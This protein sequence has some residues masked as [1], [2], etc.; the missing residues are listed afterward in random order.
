[1]PTGVLKVTEGMDN[2]YSCK[3]NQSKKCFFILPSYERKA[4]YKACLAFRLLYDGWIHQ[5]HIYRI[6]LL[7][8]EVV[9]LLSVAIWHCPPDGAIGRH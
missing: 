2:S 3:K 1:M 9:Y 7:Q 5:K 6:S 4:E 8:L